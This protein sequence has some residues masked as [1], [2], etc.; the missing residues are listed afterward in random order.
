[1]DMTGGVQNSPSAAYSRY[2]VSTNSAALA[3]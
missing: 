1:M 3:Y 2:L